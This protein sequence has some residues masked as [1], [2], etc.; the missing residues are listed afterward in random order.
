[1]AI[2]NKLKNV[3]ELHD[4]KT[5]E[6]IEMDNKPFLLLCVDAGSEDYE[7]GEFHAIRGRSATL[8]FLG[9]QFGNFD[10]IHSYVMSGN[11]HFGEEV[12]L[13]SFMRIHIKELEEKEGITLDDLNA[14]AGQYD[15]E[16][17]DDTTL[18]DALYI[19][20]TNRPIK[21]N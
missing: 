21:T 6:I 15:L 11:I 4:P 10:I 3:V 2:F 13:Y 18:L 9:M 7:N 5:G 14:L 20:E 8:E 12:S 1:M 17:Q 16:F 19:K